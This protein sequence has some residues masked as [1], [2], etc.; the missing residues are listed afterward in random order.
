[1]KTLA[2]LLL[3]FLSV[4]TEDLVFEKVHLVDYNA[5]TGNF[6]FRGNLPVINQTFVFE[7]LSADMKN[8]SE[9]LNIPFPT[10]F[11]LN[12]FSLLWIVEEPFT[13]Y[14]YETEFWSLNDSKKY[15]N[16]EEW[17]ISFSGLTLTPDMIPESVALTLAANMVEIDGLVE[18]VQTLKELLSTQF[19]KPLVIYT[20]CHHGCD[21][22]GLLVGA[23]RMFHDDMTVEEMYSRNLNEC[24][25]T[26]DY[27][28]TESLK[29]FCLMLKEL[30]GNNYGDC[31]G[32]ASCVPWDYCTVNY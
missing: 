7:T 1:M 27:M 18:K 32:F 13:D 9:A 4:L 28:A 21:R 29:W 23:Y 30:K 2:F 12:I 8:R 17:P 15:G 5:T 19:D 11:T 25:R 16:F 10:N 3:F 31:V 6:L 20:H 24:G 14:K 26:E 22:T